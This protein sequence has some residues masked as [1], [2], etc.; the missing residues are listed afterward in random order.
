MSET[1]D[2]EATIAAL[3]LGEVVGR[4]N[5]EAYRTWAKLERDHLEADE[6]EHLRRAVAHARAHN[7]SL[8]SALHSTREPAVGDAPSPSGT[9]TDLTEMAREL[10]ALRALSEAA[11]SH[12]AALLARLKTEDAYYAAWETRLRRTEDEVLA[13]WDLLDEIIRL[14]SA[15]VPRLEKLERRVGYGLRQPPSA[16]RARKPKRPRAA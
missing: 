1:F 8:R 4:R 2:L 7:R 10:N 5:F 14:S 11:R 9:P 12:Q 15:S 3:E 16:E 13:L 6:L